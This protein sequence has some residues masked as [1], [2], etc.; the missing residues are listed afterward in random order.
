MEGINGGKRSV[1]RCHDGTMFI[2]LKNHRAHRP[3]TKKHGRPEGPVAEKTMIEELSGDFMQQ[4]RGF[5]YVAKCGSFSV[6][7][8]EMRRNQS[9]V[10]YQVRHLEQSLQTTL[11]QRTGRGAV[12]TRE[13][14]ELFASVLEIFE[15]IESIQ[16]R[17]HG[18][19]GEIRGPVR[20]AF[21]PLILHS[22]LIPLLPKLRAAFPDVQFTMEQVH[23]ADAS[24]LF[25]DIASRTLDFAM[26]AA[27]SARVPLKFSPFYSS[28]TVLCMPEDMTV[29]LGDPVDMKTLAELPH[30]VS[31]S[32]RGIRGRAEEIM[33]EHGLTLHV[34]Q[35]VENMYLQAEM[36]NCG[37]GVALM[38]ERAVRSV[39]G[40]M[41]LRTVP[42]DSV[43]PA[44]RYGIVQPVQATLSPQAQKV[45][46]FFLG[47]MGA[48]DA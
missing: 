3:E 2:M 15:K 13:G 27:D 24:L 45:I 19:G 46:E 35:V 41:R 20:L 31:K 36:V 11:F 16:K 14:R 23:G 5:Y 1:R 18:Q 21:S 28:R 6:A 39:M 34:A 4:L 42:L 17:V 37:F 43:F 8:R 26:L 25:R 47:E 22:V 44:R 32:T 30:V 48:S 40:H 29:D 7:A 9:T 12:L 10:S 38:D 33:R